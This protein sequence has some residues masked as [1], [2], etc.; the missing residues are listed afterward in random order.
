[1]A[2]LRSLPILM[3]PTNPS[4]YPLDFFD[5]LLGHKLQ[6]DCSSWNYDFASK[7]WGPNFGNKTTEGCITK[8]SSNRKTGHPKFEVY[9]EDTK[10]T[11]TNLDQNYV[12]K[13][14][15]EVPLKYHELKAAYIVQ[16]S[17][18]AGILDRSQ[19]HSSPQE[20]PLATTD[21][22]ESNISDENI[23]IEALIKVPKKKK[24]EAE[25]L[26]LWSVRIRS[27]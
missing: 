21:T 2:N 9:V 13:Y 16:L 8:V 22:F 1:M 11:Y 24:K 23:A 7:I 17:R 5:G 3:A 25:S 20:E 26:Q 12:F 15:N 10:E 27:D 19:S 14:S 18:E 6:I 4:D